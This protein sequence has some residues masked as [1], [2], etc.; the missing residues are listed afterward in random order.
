MGKKAFLEFLAGG[1]HQFW[2]KKNFGRFA[3]ND[4]IINLQLIMI[5]LKT[6]NLSKNPNLPLNIFTTYFNISGSAK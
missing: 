1:N 4:E 5:S 2:S 6:Q 3:T